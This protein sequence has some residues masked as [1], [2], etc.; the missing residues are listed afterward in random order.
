MFLRSLF[1][2]SLLFALTLFHSAAFAKEA[3]AYDTIYL[4]GD[5]LADTGNDVIV[6]KILGLKPVTPPK[7]S[8]YRG[9]FSNGP[10]AFEYLLRQLKGN[11]TLYAKAFLTSRTL[12]RGAMSFAFGGSTTG[13]YSPVPPS[14]FFVPGLRGQAEMYRIA[15]NGQPANGRALFAIWS[16][17][18][19][20]F[21]GALA[22]SP[23]TP[24]QVVGNIEATI[25]RLY[26][27][28]A[29]SFI[30]ANLPDLGATPL[31][32]AQGPQFTALMRAFVDAHN[33]RLLNT[34]N[35][36]NANLPG[37]RIVHADVYS[38][39]QSLLGTPGLIASP[40][41][42]DV[43]GAPGA[44][45]CLFLAPATCPTVSTFMP[46]GHYI[47]WDA[48]HPTTEAHALLGQYMYGLL[49]Q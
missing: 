6:T 30:V 33:A 2:L 10:L 5:S 25:T 46:N 12:E 20:Y 36:L 45:F 49:L 35:S 39:V 37:V 7:G 1:S 8:Y 32:Q 24:E 22:S 44:S 9:R 41:A 26:A 19:D 13:F 42:L 14:G 40:P 38:F 3:P 34:L 31:V 48:E 43:V 11:D 23:V 4:F 17:A 29:R 15:L 27:T 21:L 18:N 16:G 47:F 28:G